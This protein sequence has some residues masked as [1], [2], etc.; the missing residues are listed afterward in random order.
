VVAGLALA[1]VPNPAAACLTPT[2]PPAFDGY[3]RDGGVDIPTDVIPVFDGQ[4]LGL[5]RPIPTDVV[6]E[7]RTEAGETIA[8]TPRQPFVWHFELVPA[9]PLAP[10]TRYTLRGKSAGELS[11]SFTT[12]AGPLVGPV[13]APRA[14]MQHYTSA[15]GYG[16]S[17]DPSIRGTCIA[18]QGDGFV[19]HVTTNGTMWTQPYL[20]R[21][22]SW[23]NLTGFEQGAPFD[24]VQLR[25]RAANGRFS[26]PVLLCGK[27]APHH[28]L[29]TANGVTCDA[30]G[31]SYKGKP[32]AEFPLY[33]VAPPP[34]VPDGGA[35][36]GSPVPTAASAAASSS[37]GC[38][39]GGTRP[40]AV[41][42]GLVLAVLVALRR[43][44]RPLRGSPDIGD[45][46]CR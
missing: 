31:L 10:H 12:G 7:L 20:H 27:D 5:G 29:P 44:S 11:L 39:H 33:P 9:S 46:C 21:G 18:H 6:F 45:S 1:A 37:S 22:Y 16:T 2:P 40:S 24:C 34:R 25:T 35:G 43:R 4:L 3:P 19:E 14:T 15:A 36:D 32:A 38:S 30:S 26:D 13:A 8:L 17:C 28:E 23:A 41:P 42:L